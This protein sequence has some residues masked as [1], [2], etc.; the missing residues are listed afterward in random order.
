[1]ARPV[2]NQVFAGP[3]AALVAFRIG[4]AVDELQLNH[5]AGGDVAAGEGFF[6]WRAEKRAR[7]S[8]A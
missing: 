3:A 2:K 4:N 8:P 7:T 1:V 5:A 6:Q